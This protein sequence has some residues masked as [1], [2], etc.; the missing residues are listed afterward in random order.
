MRHQLRH[1]LRHVCVGDL[2][3][4]THLASAF[5]ELA[6]SDYFGFGHSNIDAISTFKTLQISKRRAALT[7]FSPISYF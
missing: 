4:V 5:T 2:K 6:V 1:Q 7:R 3:Q